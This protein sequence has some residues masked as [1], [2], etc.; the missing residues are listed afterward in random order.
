[1]SKRM[2][3]FVYNVVFVDARLLSLGVIILNV[4]GVT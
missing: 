2:V 4:C 3:P 1:M